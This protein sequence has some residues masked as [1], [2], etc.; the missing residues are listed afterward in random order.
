MDRL[1]ANLSCTPQRL[2]AA[3]LATPS[4]AICS[5][6]IL[7]SVHH[8]W[9]LW[10]SVA[11]RWQ[12][13]RKGSTKMCSSTDT[14][15]CICCSGSKGQS[16]FACRSV[17]G[18]LHF[19]NRQ[20]QHFSGS[21]W[22]RALPLTSL[23]SAYSIAAATLTLTL[24]QATLRAQLALALSG[25]KFLPSSPLGLF[26]RCFGVSA[27]SAGPSFGLESAWSCGKLIVLWLLVTQDSS[28]NSWLIEGNQDKNVS[29]LFTLQVPLCRD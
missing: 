4:A 14:L 2:A 19:R 5:R 21:L 25:V 28:K 12:S 6:C 26:G 29:G 3:V 24:V 8:C 13:R 10:S 16:R 22:Y 27:S 15:F 11:A 18:L 7:T 17:L 1:S 20:R 9:C 23:W